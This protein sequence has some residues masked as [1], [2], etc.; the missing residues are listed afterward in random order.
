L[1]I[2]LACKWQLKSAI[3][4]L[5]LNFLHNGSSGKSPKF[6]FKY[7]SFLGVVASPEIPAHFYLPVGLRGPCASLYLGWKSESMYSVRKGEELNSHF[8]DVA[9]GRQTH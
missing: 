2:F 1:R 3:E 5:I 6:F 7:S 8:P 4:K 9:G